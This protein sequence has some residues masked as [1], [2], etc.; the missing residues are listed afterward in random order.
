MSNTGVNENA[1]K[2]PNVKGMEPTLLPGNRPE[3]PSVESAANDS[4]PAD[5]KPQS[6]F[7]KV[8]KGLG[9]L[10]T[11]PISI[12]YLA[13]FKMKGV[14]EPYLI[15]T[16]KSELRNKGKVGPD[17]KEKLNQG[18]VG[19]FNAAMGAGTVLG[20][21]MYCVGPAVW[22]LM[23][24]TTV[25][26]PAVAPLLVIGAIGTSLGVGM[27]AAGIQMMNGKDPHGYEK[28]K[29]PNARTGVADKSAADL[30]N[31]SK[32]GPS[33]QLNNSFGPVS[34]VTRSADGTLAR[35]MKSVE[36]EETARPMKR[37]KHD[38]GANNSASPA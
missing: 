21:L 14:I 6:T 18:G 25:I 13:G 24:A 33:N 30:D 10:V 37:I 20:A 9:V 31:A 15:E 34:G 32:L 7:S 28:K 19:M 3:A 38:S 16:A 5:K 29:D 1:S 8:L 35:E 2:A 36:P 27:M 17:R 26:S 11:A 23:M 12:P 4:A 22:T